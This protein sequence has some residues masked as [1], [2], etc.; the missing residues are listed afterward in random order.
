M[1]MVFPARPIAPLHH[2]YAQKLSNAFPSG[3]N[4]MAKMI[5]EMALMNL[6]LVDLLLVV[7]DSIS[8]TTI[9]AYFQC[10]FVIV[11]MT[12]ETA[13]MK[14]IVTPMLAME[15]NSSAQQPMLLNLDFVSKLKRNAMDIK[16]VPM[17]KMKWIVLLKNVLPANS[18]AKMPIAFLMF[19]FVMETMIAEITLTKW[20]L[21]LHVLVL[22]IILGVPKV[23]AFQSNGNV[24]EML[25]VKMVKMN[26]RKNVMFKI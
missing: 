14:K 3:G 17:L 22:K 5:V 24:T 20:N 7:Q 1:M 12:V 2:F 19:G 25:I 23:G 6:N 9:I 4:V 8:V 13:L 11:M 10:I 21:V 26:L 15:N 16:I 18:S